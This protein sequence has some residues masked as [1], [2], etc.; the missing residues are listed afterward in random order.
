[1]ENLPKISVVLF[2]AAVVH[3]THLRDFHVVEKIF[4]LLVNS[5]QVHYRAGAVRQSAWGQLP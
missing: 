1:M 3:L 4:Y 2:S 5:G